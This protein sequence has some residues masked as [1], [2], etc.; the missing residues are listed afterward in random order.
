[1]E[2]SIRKG[3]NIPLAQDLETTRDIFINTVWRTKPDLPADLELDASL[4]MVGADGKVRKDQDFIFYNNA[5]D[6]HKSVVH[7]SSR[8][9]VRDSEGFIVHLH[10]IPDDVKKLVFNLTVYNWEQHGLNLQKSLDAAVI[11]I[12][13]RKDNSTLVEYNASADLVGETAVMLGELYRHH[14]G[15]KFRAVGQGF[16]GGLR[17]L[18]EHFGINVQT[19]CSDL[20]E[21][22]TA[23]RP[24]D[25]GKQARRS[26][27]EVIDEEKKLV[28]IGLQGFLPQIK[29]ALDNQPN[30][31]GTRMLLDRLLQDVFGYRMEDMKTEQS[32]QSR[33]A[34]YVLALN[35]KDVMVI[36]AKRAGMALREKQIFQAT[37]YGAYGGIKWALL[38]NLG[39]WQLYRISTGDRIEA[40]LVFSV[41]LRHGLSDEAVDCLYLISRY[42]IKRKGLLEQLW[43]K[44]SALTSES[45]IS[46]ILTEEVIARIRHILN[47]ENDTRLTNKEVQDAVERIILQ[48]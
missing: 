33:K 41:D 24:D 25:T 11:K 26:S 29:N 16:N 18:A 9:G 2:Q 8:G 19:G 22:D 38:T 15:W 23:T 48:G 3:E 14:S 36:E 13:D 7:I 32:I 10:K 37:S 42:G 5:T 17:A 35:G 31:S 45:L 1:M 27:Q 46:A 44:A 39:S 40:N 21:A 43:A 12:I 34:D 47:K 4:F 6:E 28:R 30:E 20:D